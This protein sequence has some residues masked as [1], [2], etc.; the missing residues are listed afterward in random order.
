MEAIR[1]FLTFRFFNLCDFEVETKNIVKMQF[2]SAKQLQ[3]RHSDISSEN[4]VSFISF[5]NENKKLIFMSSFAFNEW[6][7]QLCFF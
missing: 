4:R 1:I 2:S 6:K 5:Q 3:F 7:R